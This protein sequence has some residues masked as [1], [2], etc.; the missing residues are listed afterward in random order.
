MNA[1]REDHVHPLPPGLAQFIGNVTVAE[2]TLLALGLGMKRMVVTLNGVVATD[3]L[4]FAPTG[5]ATA[6][7]EAV[8]V[9]ASAANQV[10]VSY[11]TPALGLATSYSIPLAVYRI[12]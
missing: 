3:R 6:G 7:C 5:L 11:F 8:N 4:T 2:T 12:T 1:A 9:Y 10:T